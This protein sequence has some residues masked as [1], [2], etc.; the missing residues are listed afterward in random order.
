MLHFQNDIFNFALQI[1][2][3]FYILFQVEIYMKYFAF[4]QTNHLI[5]QP[6]FYS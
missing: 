3:L 6:L 4:I 2:F 5:D 1:F